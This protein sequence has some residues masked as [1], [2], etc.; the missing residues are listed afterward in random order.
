MTVDI[1][2]NG[3]GYI[4]I[5]LHYSVKQIL[6]NRS[7]AQFSLLLLAVQTPVHLVT[8]QYK[9]LTKLLTG[10]AAFLLD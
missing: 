5:Y 3:V 1:G 4:A 8:T 10:A 9:T 2:Q 6:A 7:Y